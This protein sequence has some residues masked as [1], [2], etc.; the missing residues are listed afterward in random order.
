MS[1]TGDDGVKV[2]ISADSST[3][4]DANKAAVTAATNLTTS[5]RDVGVAAQSSAGNVGQASKD[6]TIAATAMLKA[7]VSAAEAAKF[8]GVSQ[9]QILGLASSLAQLTPQVLGTGSN[10][11][12]M[13]AAILKAT[14][15]ISAASVEFR[16]FSAAGLVADAAFKSAA[17]SAE[18][19]IKALNP[20]PI[21]A[22]RRLMGDEMPPAFRMTQTATMSVVNAMTGVS[23]SFKSAGESASVFTAAISPTAPQ[24]FRASMSAMAA[25]NVVA[26]TTIDEMI[27]ASTGLGSGFKSAADSAAAFTAQITRMSLSELRASL[28][29]LPPLIA[30]TAVNF[31]AAIDATTG[32]DR[33]FKSAADSAD[34]FTAEINRIPIGQLRAALLDVRDAGSLS[35]RTLQQNIDAA[36]GI[37]RSF[38]SASE[39]ARVFSAALDPAP[40]QRLRTLMGEQL[41]AAASAT[42]VNFQAAINAT[43]GVDRVFRSAADSADVFTREITRIPLAQLRRELGTELPAAAKAAVVDFQAL[44]DANVM[45][46]RSF[47]S[48]EESARVFEQAL[49]PA[50]LQRMR[51]LMADDVPRAAHGSGM[52]MSGLTRE[53]IVLGH[54]GLQ[55]NWTRIPGSL[56][57]L[58]EYAG[59]VRTALGNMISSFTLMQGVGVG[60]ILAVAAA[61]VTMV[62]RAHEATVA[63]NE[64][65]NAATMQGRSPA[66]AR[67]QMTAYGEQMKATGVMGATAMVQ[68]A[69]SISQLGELTEQQKS[70]IAG[71]GTALFLNWRSDAKK[72]G[73]E[74]SQIFASTGS[75]DSYLQKQHLLSTE[76]QT[77]WSQATT[78]AQKYDIG[79]AAITARLGPMTDKI[80][81]QAD[82]ALMNRAI[83]QMTPEGG[84]AVIGKGN[85]DMPQHLGDFEP[86]TK[87]AD[88]G[89]VADTQAVIEGNKH[90]QQ[91]LDLEAQLAAQQRYLAAATASGNTA[92]QNLAQSAIEA[93]Q[94][95]IT[96]W[97]AAGD[98]TWE[99]K[100]QGA[101]N[102]IL[103]GLATHATTSKQLAQDENQARVTFWENQAR[104]A[105]LT[106]AQITTATANASRAR[107]ALAGEE[108]RGLE[109]GQSGW[110]AKQ[111]NAL[112][113]ILS[114]VASHATSSRQLAI[115][116][117]RA[118]IGFWDEQA[119]K[120]GLTEKEITAAHTMASR[121]RM[122]LDAEVLRGTE[123]GMASWLGKQQATLSDILVGVASTA[124]SSKTLAQDENKARI[125][126]WDELAQQSG[127]TEREL[128]A[129]RAEGNRAR[130]SLSREELQ[131]LDSGTASWV[132][133]QHVALS[134][135]LIGVA[136]N[137]KSSKALAEDENRT[138]IT[139][140]DNAA[141]QA[142][143]TEK[144]ITA[145]R[146]EA[147]RA[148]LALSMEE[149]RGG[150]IAA[151]Q[152]LAEKLAALSAEQAAH[153]DNFTLVMTIEGQKLA[154][155][156]ASVGERTRIYQEELAKQATLERE[157]TALLAEADLQRLAT[158]RAITRDNIAE[159]KAELNEEFLEGK[160]TKQQELNTLRQF[161]ADAHAID[162]T[163]LAERIATLGQGTKALETAKNEERRLISAAAREEGQLRRDAVAEQKRDWG[164]MTAPVTSAIDS[165]VGAVLRG[166]ETIGQATAKMLEGIVS[167]YVQMGVKKLVE[168]AGQKVMEIA[169]GKATQDAVA[170]SQIAT[171]AVVAGA[172]AFADSAQLGPVGLAAAPAAAAAASGTVMGMAASLP[173]LAAGA[174][175]VPRNMGANLHAGEMVIPAN[176]AA[177][178]RDSGGSASGG[179]SSSTTVNF[180]I[181]ANDGASVR[182]MLA[183]HA[184]FIAQ[185]VGKQQSRNPSTR[186]S[187]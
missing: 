128:T 165:Q 45:L 131:A 103:V 127:L 157:H 89:A 104:T 71:V 119:Q 87:Q 183:Q 35:T 60:A 182:S 85:F 28:T 145:A 179:G 142:G 118:R 72:T 181:H 69:A 112:A 133:R 164:A 136:A 74:L 66:E 99:A 56:L 109:A 29:A 79:I 80:K 53:L 166:N 169:M 40:L 172:A 34:V 58:T 86:G 108:L 37:G 48:A 43:T 132:A 100:Q 125:K 180:H 94:T 6:I 30:D 146:A 186:A 17:E 20:T 5:L 55:G 153:H 32:V 139:F 96:L 73:E 8:F 42:V 47:K 149:L 21:Q 156:R 130:L 95:Q 83:A 77:A 140:W 76:Q 26:S 91:K 177:G 7:G 110:V 27:A 105:G 155:I 97:K 61:F 11:G 148:R 75:L 67:A 13:T 101:L 38:H 171:Q 63:I 187:F 158:A 174:W 19:F 162:I 4:T 120:A 98:T 14:Q 23:G 57:V 167:G 65:T 90:L 62:Y 106:E 113:R 154:L 173:A 176:F 137:A 82:E 51:K 144:E 24:A 18:V 64:A 92:E 184:P 12:A 88:P 151:K 114:D 78:A 39:S 143:L 52:A 121:A 46:G 115:D 163:A 33:S 25:A 2:T 117:N 159:K 116:E 175:N 93:T 9:T 129:V 41:P 134:E 3:F 49:N 50:P 150:E 152:G 68:V 16:A 84:G 147:N 59:G 178:L 1:G 70:K 124:T 185:Q 141:K 160:I 126:F 122:A 44:I 111:E 15:G 123:A 81:E 10:M 54:E 36:N 22:L 107:M 102:T 168:L 31:R 170:T 161:A 138:R 135:I